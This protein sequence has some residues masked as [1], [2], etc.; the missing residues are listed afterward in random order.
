MN[1]TEKQNI[2]TEIKDFFS[3]RKKERGLYSPNKSILFFLISLFFISLFSATNI[4]QFSS[5]IKNNYAKNIYISVSQPFVDLSEKLKTNLLFSN[6]R[7]KFLQASNLTENFNWDDFYYQKEKTRLLLRWPKPAPKIKK[8]KIENKTTAVPPKAIQLITSNNNTPEKTSDNDELLV[9][10]YDYT[11]KNP[12]KILFAGDSEMECFSDGFLRIVGEKSP[13][14]I[15]S[16]AVPSSGF[17]R[18]DYYNWP[19]KFKS[20]FSKANANKEPFDCAVLILGMNDYQN[21][22]DGK[23]NL[24][25]RGTE[26]WKKAYIEKIRTYFDVL[27]PN[28]KKIYWLGLPTVKSKTINQQISFIEECQIEAA[29]ILNTDGKIEKI[30]IREIAP[31]AGAP[32]TDIFQTPEGNR[33]KIMRSDGTHLTISGG[34]FMMKQIMKK[35]YIDF[36]IELTE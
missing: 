17:I 18:T 24:F 3:K 34:E 13:F 6:T 36:D 35:F 26:E 9:V 5:D 12:L 21:F 2:K 25:K 28:V 31:G 14:K 4:K 30:S 15:V 11:K 27:Q 19:A 7:K 10:S 22:F 8:S 32:Y 23:G 20:I 33:I 29:K 16:Y 1:N